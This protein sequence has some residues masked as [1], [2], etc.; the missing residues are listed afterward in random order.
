MLRYIEV[1]HVRLM[2]RSDEKSLRYRLVAAL[3]SIGHV[4]SSRR[5]TCAVDVATVEYS[6]LSEAMCELVEV[7]LLWPSANLHQIPCPVWMLCVT[8]LPALLDS[9]PMDVRH[10]RLRSSIGRYRNHLYMA[11]AHP[12]IKLCADHESIAVWSLYDP[13]PSVESRRQ[14]TR[15]TGIQW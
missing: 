6:A 1:P 7:L 12:L 3:T 15:S 13:P 14:Q 4:R 8:Q 10:E 9:A 2:S 11:M 5:R